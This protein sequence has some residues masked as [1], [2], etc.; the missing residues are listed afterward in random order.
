MTPGM[1]QANDERPRSGHR[2]RRGDETRPLMS[3]TGKQ[4]QH[5]QHGTLSC[6]YIVE[7]HPTPVRC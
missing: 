3:G 4:Q 7:T 1:V 5:H 6:R 2:G